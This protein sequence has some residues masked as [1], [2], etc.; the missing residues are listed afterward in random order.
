MSC[1]CSKTASPSNREPSE[2]CPNHGS[3]LLDTRELSKT[4]TDAAICR[5]KRWSA[6]TRIVGDEG[7]G[8]TEIEITAIG[9][10]SI[11]ARVI[12][13]GTPG[14]YESTWIL[15]CR[16]WQEVTQ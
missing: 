13:D 12:K 1:T 2:K 7:Y 6:G 3:V 9:Y 14:W 16:D 8:P 15:S 5:M 11:L 10:N 4:M